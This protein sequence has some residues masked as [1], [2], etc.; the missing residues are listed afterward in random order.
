MKAKK[1]KKKIWRK[2]EIDF[3]ILS[4]DLISIKFYTVT[5]YPNCTQMLPQ[6]LKFKKVFCFTLMY[7]Y[8]V[9]I[10]FCS[11]Y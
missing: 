9:L 10:R 3:S 6:K 1:K 11:V 5:Y 7:M 8:N 2:V 4:H